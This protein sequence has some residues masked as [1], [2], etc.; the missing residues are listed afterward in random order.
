VNKGSLFAAE[1]R[2]KSPEEQEKIINS[3]KWHHTLHLSLLEHM[4]HLKLQKALSTSKQQRKTSQDNETIHLKLLL[5]ISAYIFVE[6][7]A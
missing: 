4:Q 7:T 5:G 1:G 3:E 6:N 2:Q